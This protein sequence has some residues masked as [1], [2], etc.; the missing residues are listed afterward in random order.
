MSW[1]KENCLSLAGLLKYV[2]ARERVSVLTFVILKQW[3]QGRGELMS[4]M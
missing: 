4:E 2:S 1:V 3:H